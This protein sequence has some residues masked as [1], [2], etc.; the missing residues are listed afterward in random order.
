MFFIPVTA[1]NRPD[2]HNISFLSYKRFLNN[3]EFCKNI[4]WV[5]NIDVINKLTATFEETETNLIN[6][7]RTIYKSEKIIILPESINP[8]F[9]LAV[10]KLTYYLADNIQIGD[11]VFWL[12]DDWE[13]IGHINYDDIKDYIDDYTAFHLFWQ[14]RE[15]TL[16]PKIRGYYE[17]Q[18]FIKTIQDFDDSNNQDPEC[19]LQKN[20]PKIQK[21][22]VIWIIRSDLEKIYVT[23]GMRSNIKRFGS[24]GSR[25]HNVLSLNDV[26]KSSNNKCRHIVYDKIMSKDLG[27]KYMLSKT[28]K[29]WDFNDKNASYTNI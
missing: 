26:D 12:E 10:K 14:C 23:G 1:I 27:R 6:Q 25:I 24:L 3:D 15:D 9:Q 21:D 5:I 11:K 2:L 17:I 8:S 7:I 22:F 20:Y 13:Y 18:H 29:K 16:Y 4:T 28:L 19:L